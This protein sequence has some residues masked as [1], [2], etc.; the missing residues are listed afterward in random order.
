MPVTLT[1]QNCGTVYTRPKGDE[2]RGLYCSLT[3]ARARQHRR[4]PEERFWRKVRRGQDC[5][6]WQ[7]YR[8]SDG[9]GRW[10]ADY[11]RGGKAIRVLAH[12]YSFELANGPIPD[13]AVIRHACDNPPCV[14]P[15]HL[16]LGD[17][18]ANVR[19]RDERGRRMVKGERHPRAVL[20]DAIVL[21]IRARH[22]TGESFAAI[23]AS[24]GVKQTTVRA[25]CTGQN[26]GH[27]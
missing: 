5:W 26:W 11:E 12:R 4:S 3:C 17:A 13:G 23:A 18:A 1:C 8:I 19:D 16:S 27:L 24:L 2:G 14:N 25:A 21:G 6:E 9:Y 7:G 22:A 15:T 20:T 10:A